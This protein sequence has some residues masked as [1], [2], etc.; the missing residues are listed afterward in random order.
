MRGSLATLKKC[1]ECRHNHGGFSRL[2]TH[3]ITKVSSDNEGHDHEIQ[4]SW[5]KKNNG[6]YIASCDGDIKGAW[7]VTKKCFDGVKLPVTFLNIC[8]AKEQ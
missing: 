3:M 4:I 8:D 1:S 7:I 5:Y 6:F 2:L